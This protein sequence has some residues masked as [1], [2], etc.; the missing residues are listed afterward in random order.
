MPS[1]AQI[2]MCSRVLRHDTFIG[3]NHQ[4]DHVDAR[5]A[6]HH[7][8]DEL[9]VSGHIHNAHAQ[10]AG[11]LEVRETQFDRDASQLLFFQTIG[12][13]AGQGFDQAGLAMV[14]M[15]G[16]SQ[17]DL[18]HDLSAP[19]LCP[20]RV[21]VPSILSSQAFNPLR[22]TLISLFCDRANIR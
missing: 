10:A 2:S 19:M 16:G 12:I 22:V 6:G 4:G 18:L 8:F 13:D 21:L 20:A 1:K 17:Y 5:G 15:S 7:V 9:F 11:K 3:G 14:D